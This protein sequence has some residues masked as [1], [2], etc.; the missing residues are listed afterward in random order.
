METLIPALFAVGASV[1]YGFSD[2]FAGVV[3]RRHTVASVALWAQ[4][5]GLVALAVAVAI[6]RPVFFIPTLVWGAIGGVV[7]AL[8]ILAFYTALQHGHTAIVAP[9]AGA[10]VLIPVVVGI[11][12]GDPVSVFV[13]V[14]IVLTMSGIV[15]VTAGGGRGKLTDQEF[16]LPEP[17]PPTGYIS[18]GVPGRSQRVPMPDGCKPVERSRTDGWAIVLAIAAA[19]GFGGFFIF[20][21]Q[22]TVSAANEGLPGFEATLI[23]TFAVQVG[24][25]SVT[26]LATLRHSITCLRP[27]RSLM[28]FAVSVGLFDAVADF[29]L[30]IAISAGPLA[31]VGPLGSL[32]PVI[33]V[34][35][36]IFVLREK[37]NRG[38][39]VGVAVAVIGIL[40][41][42][43]T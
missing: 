29:L 20:L 27:S 11:A 13:I 34:L 21:D 22:A 23:A 41:I 38:Q 35:L 39:A 43:T 32:D 25:L 15:V 33:A 40:L 6:V 19:V 31:V 7:G 26:V 37:L 2:V 10:G 8:A 36:A 5:A 14:G 28:I 4:V 17:M 3:V 12:A 9:L 1:L 16:D 24:A 42:S 18:I 30:T